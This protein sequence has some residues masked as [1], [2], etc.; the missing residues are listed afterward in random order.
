MNID[1]ADTFNQQVEVDLVFIYKF[2]V[3]HMIDRCTRWHAGMV[4]PDKTEDTLMRAIDSCWVSTH[5]PMKELITDGESGICASAETKTYLFRKG[6]KL[7]QRGKAT[8]CQ[9]SNMQ[10]PAN[11]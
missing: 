10:L 3:F 1:F 5:G 9:P 11:C 8:T 7:H 6:I 2:I 4:I